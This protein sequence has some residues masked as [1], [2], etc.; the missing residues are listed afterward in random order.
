MNIVSKIE[1]GSTTEMKIDSR[2]LEESLRRRLE[3]EVRFDPGSR[4]LYSTDGS[5]YRQVPIGVVI[6]R[7]GE[8]V[9]HTVATCREFGA[10]ILSRGGGTSLAGQ[11]CNVAVVMDFSKWL[12]QVLELD[13]ER[14]LARVEPGCVLDD[15]RH[16]AERFH[17]TFGPDPA[18]HNHNTLAG[19]IGNDSCGVHSVMAG[20]DR[21]RTADNLESLE[22]LTYDG[23]RMQVGRTGDEE[24]D[25]IIHE[26]GRRGQIYQAMRSLRDKYADEIR[27]KFPRIPRRVSGYNLDELLPEKGFNV[28]R[29][30]A[31]SEG[32]LVTYLEA[33]LQLIPSPPS[34]SVLI[35][36]YPD[37]YAAGDHIM[38]VMEFR[39]TGCEGMD[40][41]LVKYMQQKNMHLNYLK[42]LPP[43]GG[44]LLLEFGGDNREE[45]DGKARQLMEALKDKPNAPSMKLFDD[46]TEE[47]HVWKVREGGLGATARIPG[48]GDAWPGWEDSAVP[49]EKVGSY[50]RDLRKLFGK[51]GYDCSLY[52]HFGQGCIHVR[53]DFDLYTADGIRKYMQFMEEAADTVVRYGGSLSGEHGD[54]QARAQFLPRMFGNKLIEAFREFK[55]IWDPDWKMNPGKVV[56]PYRADENLRLG[57]NYEPWEPKTHFQWPDDNGRFSR[58]VLRCV[59]VGECRRE[60]GGTMCPSYRVTRDDQHSTRGRAR[61]LFEMLRGDVISGWRSKAVRD[62]LDLCLACKGCK[63]DCPVSVDMATYKAE[64]LS[65]Y[66]RGRVRP[67]HA[68]S[69]GLI[70]WWAGLA[71]KVPRLV[72]AVTQ[73]PGLA[74]VAKL[75]GGFSQRRRI[76][77]FAPYT[78]RQAYGRRRQSNGGRHTNAVP[79]ERVILWADTFNNYFH[80]AVGE[81]ALNVLES[82]GF[83]VE[84]PAQNLCCGRPLYDYGMLD[85]AE[86]LLDNILDTLRP[87][88]REGVPIVVLEPSCAAVFRDEL[89]GLKAADEDAKRLS[90]QT[91]L[92]SE[93]LEKKVPDYK[94]PE[95]H[96]KAI[97]HGHCHH[98][99]VMKM[100][101]EESIL[102][103]M[104]LDYQMLDSGCCGMAGGFGF[105]KEHY[106]VSIAVGE[107]VLLPAVRAQERETII[108]AD[109]FSCREQIAQTTDRRA[110]HLAQVLDMAGREGPG[111]PA[112]SAA[113]EAGYPDAQSRPAARLSVGLAFAAGVVMGGVLAWGIRRYREAR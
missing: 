32:T 38:E 108:I 34:R 31:G 40:D 53:I 89:A 96:R 93:F 74:A 22:I 104:R 6:P 18:T 3:G 5:N 65:H 35:L 51:Y 86:R 27:A 2:G 97:V 26:G 24:I 106:D 4:A 107:Q 75:L 82:L 94:P 45:S 81:A 49:P 63:G 85:L 36:G 13:P 87:Q 48:Q 7:S 105:E 41:L 95:L 98:K 42:M 11:C 28:A 70:H 68:Y 1:N 84:V 72:N 21:A 44:W 60:Q 12:R 20:P 23:I 58:A 33:T 71:S 100:K 54:G 113:P 78:M 15:L 61:L 56:D 55:R 64:F 67:V 103:K 76:P 17:L 102:K 62:A 29:A 77:A 79:R 91:Y 39:P 92:L 19:M 43:G 14:K 109:G 80:P 83:D 90:R 16:R 101:D 50:L 57:A 10:P 59:G 25:Q 66:Y 30:L 47:Q 46:K 9:V 112:K 69:I 8:D 73:T 88:I 99:A 111:G 52:G 37:V 110:L